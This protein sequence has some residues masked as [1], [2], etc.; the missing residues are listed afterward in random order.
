MYLDVECVHNKFQCHPM[1]TICVFEWN[2]Q[3]DISPEM[4][5][6][7][8]YVNRSPSYIIFTSPT[9]YGLVL[10]VAEGTNDGEGDGIALRKQ[11]RMVL[12]HW[13]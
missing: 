5:K 1:T 7:Q 9:G 6:R 10:S 4:D 3:N 13:L 8:T 12:L 2:E 11:A